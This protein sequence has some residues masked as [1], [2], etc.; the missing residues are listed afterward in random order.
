MSVLCPL[1][2]GEEKVNEKKK[3]SDRETVCLCVSAT[4]LLS[5]LECTLA[6]AVAAVST[7]KEGAKTEGETKEEEEVTPIVHDH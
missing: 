4:E 6:G 5:A 1:V 3:N 2:S 7:L